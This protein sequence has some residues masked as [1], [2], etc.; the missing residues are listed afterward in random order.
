MVGPMSQG[1][2]ISLTCDRTGSCPIAPSKA[3]WGLKSCC[4]SEV[5]RLWPGQSGT[6]WHRPAPTSTQAVSPLDG[7]WVRQIEA[8]SAATVVAVLTRWRPVHTS[9]HCPAPRQLSVKTKVSLRRCSCYRQELLQERWC[10]LSTMWQKFC[11]HIGT[12]ATGVRPMEQ[13]PG[14]C[15]LRRCEG[16]SALKDALR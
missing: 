6:V 16:P 8:V 12:L 5:A 11:P 13:S 2:A 14:W 15:G 7:A 10:S 9:S 1:S 4:S 3:E